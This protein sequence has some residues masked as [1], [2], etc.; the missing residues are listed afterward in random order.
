MVRACEVRRSGPWVTAAVGIVV[1]AVF[2]MGLDVARA[3]ESSFELSITGLRELDQTFEQIKQQGLGNWASDKVKAAVRE[4]FPALFGPQAESVEKVVKAGEHTY[5]INA[6]AVDAVGGMITEE[7]ASKGDEFYDWLERDKLPQLAKDV[8]PDS[9][10]G[11]VEGAEHLADDATR[12]AEKGQQAID[13]VVSMGDRLSEYF[14]EE[15]DYGLEPGGEDAAVVANARGASAEPVSPE[16]EVV[17]QAAAWIEEHPTVMTSGAAEDP[18]PSGPAPDV[19]GDEPIVADTRPVRD[20]PKLPAGGAFADDIAA[21]ERDVGGGGKKASGFDSDLDALAADLGIDPAATG[22]KQTDW[23]EEAARA[24]SDSRE[25]EAGQVRKAEE[26]RQLDA[27][28]RQKEQLARQARLEAEAAQAAAEREYRSSYAD[29]SSSSSSSKSGWG[30]LFGAVVVGA[31]QG[32]L[33]G[34]YGVSTALPSGNRGSS[35]GS[36]SAG[37]ACGTSQRAYASYETCMEQALRSNSNCQRFRI[38]QRCANDAATNLSSCPSLA[39]QFR[40]AAS[41]A[42][43]SAKASCAN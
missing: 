17:A 18:T 25:W 7:S 34:K 4:E 32:Y 31:A 13:S 29:T 14:S 23:A 9:V 2:S 15:T 26:Q 1:A 39:Q 21:L 27:L 5:S 30:S 12:V 6:K 43:E 3:E 8:V 42:A 41:S 20:D 19:Q 33:Q 36:A 10:R 37:S 24:E 35:G 22:N 28:R 40:D 38:A 11:I 16:P